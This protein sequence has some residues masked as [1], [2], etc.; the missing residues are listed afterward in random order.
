[1]DGLTTKELFC[2]SAWG[3]ANV[4]NNINNGRPR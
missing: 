2:G 1:M 3:Q 4:F